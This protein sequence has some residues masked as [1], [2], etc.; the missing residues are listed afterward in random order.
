MTVPNVTGLLP[1]VIT[2]AFPPV[3]LSAIAVLVTLFGRALLWLSVS[4]ADRAALAPGANRTVTAQLPAGRATGKAP[5]SAGCKALPIQVLAVTVKS[6]ALV[7]EITAE[8]MVKER[9]VGSG[10][11]LITVKT[12]DAVEP[13]LTVPKFLAAGLTDMVGSVLSTPVEVNGTLKS[14]VL[15]ALPVKLKLAW[16]SPSAVGLNCTDTVHCAP[17]ANVAGNTRGQAPA[18]ASGPRMKSPGFAPAK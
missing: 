13:P 4:V 8:V 7:P 10:L 14:V 16:R 18:G 3:P 1:K 5:G 11:V 6:L 12:C 15:A 9:A 17:A 2:A